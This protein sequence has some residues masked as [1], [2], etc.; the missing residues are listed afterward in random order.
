ME[1]PKR[2]ELQIVDDSVFTKTELRNIKVA[3]NI[4]VIFVAILGIV[5]SIRVCTG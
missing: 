1:K 2:P 4:G 5:Q 3:L